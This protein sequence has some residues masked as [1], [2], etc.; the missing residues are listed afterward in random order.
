MPPIPE[1]N[2][3]QKYQASTEFIVQ[4]Q[5][6]LNVFINRVVRNLDRLCDSCVRPDGKGI[7][8]Q[9]ARQYV[10]EESLSRLLLGPRRVRA[11]SQGGAMGQPCSQLS[12]GVRTV[13]A[14]LSLL[15]ASFAGSTPRAGPEP[16]AAG[17]PRG[18]RAGLADRAG[19]RLHWL[20]S[21]GTLIT[22][23]RLR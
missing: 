10:L 5:Q 11:E 1:K 19:T 3:V 15:F 22:Y 9:L 16:R 13:I 23:R 8:Q 12:R 17:V 14:M 6:A 4:R 21:T 2:V 7:C 20:L 18:R